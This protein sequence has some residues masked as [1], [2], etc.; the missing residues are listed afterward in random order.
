MISPTHSQTHVT[1][2]TDPLILAISESP[3]SPPLCPAILYEGACMPSG[4]L[5]IPE[6]TLPS[7]MPLG[8]VGDL[9]VGAAGR[10]VLLS[11]TDGKLAMG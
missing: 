1:L 6:W 3:D 4:E 11:G 8:E 7:Q 9:R 5:P 2:L 10:V